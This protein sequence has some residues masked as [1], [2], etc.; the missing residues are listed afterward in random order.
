MSFLHAPEAASTIHLVNGSDPQM[1][2]LFHTLQAAGLNALWVTGSQSLSDVVAV[3]EPLAPPTGFSAIHVYGHGQPGVQEFGGDPITG[4]NLASQRNSW[5]RLGEL[6]HADADLLLFGCSVGAGKQGAALLDQLAAYTGMDVAASDD[7]TGA[8]DWELEQ[9]RGTLEHSAPAALQHWDGTLK[10]VS[11]SWMNV[12]SKQK[13]QTLVDAIAGQRGEDLRKASFMGYHLTNQSGSNNNVV[14][15][16]QDFWDRVEQR[17]NGKLNMTVLASDANVPGSDNE[18]LLGVANGRFDA[19]TAN[20][21]IYSGVI[22]EVANLMTLLFAYNDSAE[23][24]AVVNDPIFRKELLKAGEPYQLRFLTKGTL[25]SGMRDMTTI[26]G[27]PINSASDLTGFKLRIPPSTAVQSQLQA[28]GVIP[29]LTPVSQL[30]TVLESGEV[31]GQENPPSFIETFNLNGICNQLSL[32]NHLWTGFLTAINLDT[33]ESWPKQW[34]KIVL[35]EQKAMQDQQWIAQDALN[36]QIIE[37][38]PTAHD[39]TVVKPSGLEEIDANASFVASRNQVI[40]TLTPSLRPIA[41]AIVNGYY[42]GR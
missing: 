40:K 6:S 18:A 29:Y 12:L 41:R 9:R 26:P 28:L 13:E 34:R 21:P 30:T 10:T 7:I 15:A 8:D 36:Q 32:T 19:V 39:M 27:H 5:Q 3:L 35:S 16:L 37:T 17:T 1:L 38:A 42:A 14:E 11:P 24:R 4:D 33:W 31:W 20:G 2:G 22:P 25:N 23:G